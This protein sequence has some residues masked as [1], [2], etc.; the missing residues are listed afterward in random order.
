MA[1]T[2]HD[3]ARLPNDDCTAIADVIYAETSAF[4]RNDLEA[5]K[6][7]FVHDDRTRD[8]MMSSTAGLSVLKGWPAI[9]AHMKHVMEGDAG[10]PMVSFCQKNLQISISGDLAWAVFDDTS[11]FASGNTDEMF[12]TRILERQNGDW[13]IVYTSFVSKFNNGPGGNVVGVDRTGKIVH[14]N[15]AVLAALEQHPLFS[16][17]AGRLRAHRREWDKELQ[18]AISKAAKHHGFFET[19]HV[20]NEMG[21]IVQYPVVL[22]HSDGGGVA[23]TQVSVRDC[24]TYVQ[25]DSDDVLD[26]RLNFA[27][28][29]FGL[30]PGQTGVARLIALGD[31]PKSIAKILGISVNTVRTHLSRLYEK[32]GVSTQ[33]ALVRL[34]LSVG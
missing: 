30:S 32:T 15:P 34:L 11:T 29:V 12:E 5:W 24:V 19:H 20:A 7:C 4:M 33:A 8:V 17:S 22:G 9:E 3:H 1:D 28:T 27:Q 14:A 16:V 13:K 2:L 26:R 18:Q 23:V 6:T 25:L 10:C 21:A 31:G